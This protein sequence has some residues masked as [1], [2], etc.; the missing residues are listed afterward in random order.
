LLIVV[1]I[2]VTF[3]ECAVDVGDADDH[4]PV[5]LPGGDSAGG[6][7]F[8]EILKGPVVVLG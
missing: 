4:D 2:S 3:T 8:G 6:Q 7:G 1:F 5:G